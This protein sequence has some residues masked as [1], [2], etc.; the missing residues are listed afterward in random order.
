MVCENEETKKRSW[1]MGW[2]R[3]WTIM[4][5]TVIGA[6]NLGK[7]DKDL[8]KVLMEPYRGTDI[9]AGGSKGIQTKDGKDVWDVVIESWGKTDKVPPQPQVKA[10]YT[11]E[12]EEA[13]ENYW[14]TKHELFNE[15]TE[16]NYGW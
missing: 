12:E 14:V 4:E 3:G 8:L 6:Y 13:W 15:I 9:D 10:V 1:I 16:S 7:L 11:D 5:E 2:N